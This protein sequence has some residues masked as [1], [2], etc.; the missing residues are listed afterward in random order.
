MIGLPPG[1][2]VLLAAGATDMRMNFDGSAAPVQE[3]MV[4]NPFSGSMFVFRGK[5]G[6]RIKVLWF[7][8]GGVSLF[9]K[10]LEEG[11]FVWPG[12]GKQPSRCCELG[13][14]YR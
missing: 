2:R 5:G 6:D 9:A 8:G 7:S 13:L 1:T 11:K 3:S 10:R 4:H 14:V 12:V